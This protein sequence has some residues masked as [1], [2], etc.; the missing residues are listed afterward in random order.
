[1]NNYFTSNIINWYL[2]HKRDLPWRETKDPYTIWLSEIILQ[3]T[4]IKQGLPYFNKFLN[5]YPTIKDFSFAKEDDILKMWQGLGYYSRAQNMVICANIIMTKYKGK[6]PDNYKELLKLKGIGKYTAAAI[7]SFCFNEAVPV[8]DGNV[9]RVLA[10][11]FGIID[12][13]SNSK[14]FQVFFNKANE[15][16]D[17]NQPALFNESIMEFGELYCTPKKYKC[18][19]CIFFNSCFANLHGMQN[20]LP[21]KS[22][23]IKKRIRF[24][25]YFIVKY[26]NKILIKKRAK[27]DIWSGLYDFLLIEG[28]KSINKN[29]IVKNLKYLNHHQMY[30][31]DKEYKHILTHQI[32]FARFYQIDINTKLEFK[33]IKDA[34]SLSSIHVNTI[35]DYP[36]SVLVDNFLKNDYF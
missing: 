7:A 1:M 20:E 28:K 34:Y 30:S 16:I 13:L 33:I 3:Q 26:K 2:K 9:Y 35:N 29:N 8:V 4:K 31:S 22:K 25:Y 18:K 6:F 36:V 19:A 32:I 11:N 15:L 10:R 24:F 21:I 5:K 27:G 12:D 23:K 17:N 14:T